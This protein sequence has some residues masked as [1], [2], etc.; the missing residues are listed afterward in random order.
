MKFQIPAAWMIAFLPHVYATT[1][2]KLYDPRSPRTFAT[3]LEKD[4]AID[5]SVRSLY[6]LFVP[7]LNVQP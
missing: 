7:I 3:I 2:T 4:Q 1:Q 5:K 6:L